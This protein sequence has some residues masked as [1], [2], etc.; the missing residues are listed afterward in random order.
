M[1]CAAPRVTFDNLRAL[2]IADFATS[3]LGRRTTEERVV[4][5]LTANW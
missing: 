5:T 4:A 1:I 2:S 3:T